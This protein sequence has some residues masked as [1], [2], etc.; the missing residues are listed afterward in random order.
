MQLARQKIPGRSRK[1]RQPYVV[2]DWAKY[3]V[4]LLTSDQV[5]LLSD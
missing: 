3:F 2:G 1:W 4:E 5:F